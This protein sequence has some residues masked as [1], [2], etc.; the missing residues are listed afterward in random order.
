MKKPLASSTRI[1]KLVDLI[2]EALRPIKCLKT[3]LYDVEYPPTSW[4]EK[5]RLAMDWHERIMPYGGDVVVLIGT[6][7]HENYIQYLYSNVVKIAAPRTIA[8]NK[9]I[10]EIAISAVEKINEL[11]S[12]EKA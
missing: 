7:V 8:S 9:A 2:I 1:G 11:I 6:D 5:N 12:E 10:N 4:E 3:N